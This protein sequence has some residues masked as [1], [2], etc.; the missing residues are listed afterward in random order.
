Y[1]PVLSRPREHWDGAH[2]HVQQHL[3]AVLPG[4]GRAYLCGPAEMVKS[5]S[6]AL[7]EM[8]WPRHRIHYDRHDGCPIMILPARASVASVFEILPALCEQVTP[9]NVAETIDSR[10]LRFPAS[11]GRSGEN[12]VR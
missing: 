1:L 6:A 7:S 4:P 5:A 2:G 3:V 9:V 12:T 11:A 10:P 8:G